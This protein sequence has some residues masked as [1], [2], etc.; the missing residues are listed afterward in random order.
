MAKEV[1]VKILIQKTCYV[2]K[3][4][5]CKIHLAA[6]AMGIFEDPEMVNPQCVWKRVQG[7]TTRYYTD[8]TWL[9]NLS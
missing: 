8:N 1:F 5:L 4:I 7:L 3:T 9:V 2:L 6:P